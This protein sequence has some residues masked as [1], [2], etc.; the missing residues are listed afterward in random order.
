MLQQLVTNGGSSQGG[1]TDTIAQEQA[2]LQGGAAGDQAFTQTA[3]YQF[4]MQQ[5]T[6]AIDRMQL[7]VEP[8]ALVAKWLS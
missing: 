8:L 7:Q 5:G 4:A 1:A 6:Q 3:G 2:L